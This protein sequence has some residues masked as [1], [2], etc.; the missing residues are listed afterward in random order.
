MPTVVK[1]VRIDI[2][3]NKLYT[4]IAA[5]PA[6]IASWWPSFELVQR[7]S[8][9]TDLKGSCWR[10]VFNMMNLRIKGEMLVVDHDP[11]AYLLMETRSGLVGQFE[12]IFTPKGHGTDL[13]ICMDY[14]LPGNLIGQLFDRLLIETRIEADLDRGLQELRNNIES[15]E[16]E[17]QPPRAPQA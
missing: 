7:N 10:Y 6:N 1:S 2:P 8:P 9:G 4:Y 16:G 12:F 3:T 15:S 5:Q 14:V 11:G 17:T 13:T